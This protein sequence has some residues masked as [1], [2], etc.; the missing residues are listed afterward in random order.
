MLF[1]P[2]QTQ[3]KWLWFKKSRKTMQRVNPKIEPDG[4]W[5]DKC[6]YPEPIGGDEMI[7]TL[8]NQILGATAV[9][10]LLA[11][12]ACAQSD[13]AGAGRAAIAD[14]TQIV[15]LVP[16]LSARDAL[17]ASAEATGYRLREMTQLPALG[18]HMLDFDLA[19]G[20]TGPEAIAALEALEPASTVGVNHA[21]H[22]EP[23][24]TV[25]SRLDYAGPLLRWPEGG[26]R[27]L[28]PVGLIDTA[29]DQSASKLAG[30]NLV[31]RAFTGGQPAPS[32]HGT[33]IASVLADPERLTGLTIYSADVVG[34][35]PDAGEAAGA[36]ALIEALDWL[37]GQG[38]RVVN[39][40]LAG[41]YNKLLD[42]AV[43]AAAGKGMVIVAAVG[44]EGPDAPPLFPAALD[45]VVAVTAV[46]ADGRLYRNAVRGAHV[47]V[48]APGV[49]ILVEN[50]PNSRFVSGT[51]IATAFVTAR[52]LADPDLMARPDANAVIARLAATSLDLGAT[53]PDTQFGAGLV[54]AS[55]ACGGGAG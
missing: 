47:D 35:T 7:A 46:D 38:V 19:P 24:P 36:D 50:G 32:R 34:N 28:G 8:K 16:S 14:R 9:T 3:R 17:R 10:A 44:N 39:V 23:L 20:V 40:A 48:A 1:A 41:P 49:D 25:S 30:A 54:Q 55:G 31:S 37:S 27:A 21:F 29:I 13:G 51:S 42:R 52:I 4:P 33:E 5:T 53:G 11:M 26:C 45:D 12:G 2:F 18:L 6:I 15:A 43:S 22:P